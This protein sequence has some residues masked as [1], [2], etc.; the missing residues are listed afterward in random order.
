MQKTTKHNDIWAAEKKFE[1]VIWKAIIS[2]RENGT[3]VHMQNQ[4]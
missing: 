3:G 1:Q 2:L 4:C